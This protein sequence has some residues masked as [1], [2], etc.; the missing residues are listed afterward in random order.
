MNMRTPYRCQEGV[1][2]LPSRHSMEMVWPGAMSLKKGKGWLGKLLAEI[3][4]WNCLTVYFAAL[5]ERW[6]MSR[7]SSECHQSYG[8]VSCRHL[9][10]LTRA[11]QRFQSFGPRASLR[12]YIFRQLE[13]PGPLSQP[14]SFDL[15]TPCPCKTSWWTVSATFSKDFISS[16]DTQ[17]FVEIAAALNKIP[18]IVSLHGLPLNNFFS[19]WKRGRFFGDAQ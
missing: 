18:V 15:W 14:S 19:G 10:L 9:V 3:K 17:A 2:V 12:G 16:W 13:T 5:V 4:H 7:P 6:A 11:C 8:S 1:K